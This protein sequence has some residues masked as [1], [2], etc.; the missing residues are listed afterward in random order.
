MVEKTGGVETQ[1]FADSQELHVSSLPV[2]RNL[3]HYYSSLEANTDD[4]TCQ[5]EIQGFLYRPE[6]CH[7]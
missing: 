3:W 2:R 4:R 7:S 5:G 1:F 6:V